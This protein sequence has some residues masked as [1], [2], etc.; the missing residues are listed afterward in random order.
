MEVSSVALYSYLL[1]DLYGIDR[2]GLPSPDIFPG[3]S[4]DSVQ[5]LQ[6]AKSF[7][8]KLS[9]EVAADADDRC[10]KKFLSSNQRCK[11]WELTSSGSWD[12][13]LL[14][15]FNRSLEEFFYPD[16][17]PLVQ[18]Y[19]DILNVGRAGPGASLG[20]NG[21]DFYT[22]F[23]ASKLTTTSSELYNVYNEW[24]AWFPIWRDA[25]ISRAI[26]H[27]SYAITSSSSL[28]FVRK[29]RSI[30]RSICTEP[31]LN[32]FY[33]L[34]L[35][36]I[37]E[38]RLRSHFGINLATQQEINRSLA[39]RGS[40]EDSI[41]T[42][43]LESA[44]D[45]LSRSMLHEFLPGYLLDI[46]EAIRTPLTRIRGCK[47]VLNMMSTMGNGF[48]FPLQTVMFS[49]VVTAAARQKW[50]RSWSFR[51]NDPSSPWG[52]FGDDILCPKEISGGVCR[53][54][55]LLGFVVNPSKSFFEGPF[56]ES[57]GADFFNGV[58]V[59]G[60]YIKSLVTIQSRY[61]AINLL[62]EWSARTGIS[63]PRTVGY[64]VDSVPRLA[65][66][67]HGQQ[68]SGIRSPSPDL[69]GGRFWQSTKQRYLY[70]CYE[71][72][73]HVLKFSSDGTVSTPRIRGKRIRR[74]TQNPL[75]ALIAFLGGYIR[76]NSSILAL[77][78]GE[79]PSYRTR[80]R[81]SPFWG[82]DAEQLASQSAAFWRRWNSAAEDNLLG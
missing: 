70:L 33:Q 38:R 28:S 60:V 69:F 7:L 81:V 72:V 71:P 15:E 47:A 39:C 66:P 13:E 67:A 55:N 64:L 41:V 21:E 49:C 57:C 35:G 30:S 34:G 73:R 43:D 53:L 3:A 5:R 10:L 62:N 58:N 42:I 56:R 45:S 23:F 76:N 24:C 18:S 12:D 26:T 80:R 32:M 48:T 44:S 31:S 40:L 59:R 17:E 54:L 9:D 75:G 20:A 6:L 29:D 65:I 1:D 61:V 51:T 37:L 22:K 74:R 14:G 63:L 82:P 8:K 4:L 46:L 2:E 11:D 25:E 50:G 79:R 68:D 52:V 77:K 36:T 27:G 19:F 78:Q 16:G